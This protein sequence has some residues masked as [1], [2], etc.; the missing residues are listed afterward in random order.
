MG[1][2]PEI[3]T[4]SLERLPDGICMSPIRPSVCSQDIYKTNETSN[5][6]SSQIWHTPNNLLGRHF[7]HEPNSCRASAGHVN[8]DSLIRKPRFCNKL[9][10]I[11]IEANPD[12]RIS[13]V[14]SGYQEYDTNSSPRE[15]DSNQ[16]PEL[17]DTVSNGTHCSR[18]STINRVANSLNSGYIPSPSTLSPATELKKH[19]PSIRGELQQK[20]QL[21]S[22]KSRGTAVV[23]STPECL[24][25]PSH[26]Y[27]PTRSSDRNR[28]ITAGW[29][30]VCKEVRTGG[31]W[32]Q[33][34]RH[35]LSGTTCR[36]FCSEMVHKEPD[37]F[38][39]SP[40]N[41]QYNCH[42]I[43]KQTRRDSLLS[44]VQSSCRALEL[45]TQQGHDSQC[46]TFAREVEYPNRSGVETLSELQQLAFRSLSIP[47]FDENSGTLPNRSIC[48]SAECS[49]PS[50]FQLET[51]F[52]GVSLRCLSTGMEHREELCLSP[53]LSDHENSCQVTGGV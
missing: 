16:R 11:S 20:S 42:C 37:L 50:L 9:D 51:R 23:D 2:S 33:N 43:L 3:P 38:A 26:T 27:S 24:E 48:Q 53:I 52:T 13:G 45:D 18:H 14:Y 32:S 7:V 34:E 1:K 49:A 30:A 12:F 41:G 15:S 22:C 35:L 40:Q 39:C 25:R 44:T 47:C 17:S 29:G 46:R 21:Q 36:G 31:L 10:K 5:C 19:S 28:C 6:T 4:V 8:S